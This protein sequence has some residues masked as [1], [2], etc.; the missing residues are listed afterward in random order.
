[1]HVRRCGFS[2]AVQWFSGATGAALPPK[3]IRRDE[4]WNEDLPLAVAFYLAVQPLAEHV[5]AT[6]P[7]TH[8]ERRA[9][10][11]LLE[12]ICFSRLAL[13]DEYRSWREQF[14]RLTAAL[15]NAGQ[16][17]KNRL[18]LLLEAWMTEHYD[19]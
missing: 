3:Q 17:R 16:I 7:D 4:A 6:L 13:V 2:Q 10:T 14:P 12:M 15:V 9:M 8:E 5:L 19:G 11:A 1:M 18:Q